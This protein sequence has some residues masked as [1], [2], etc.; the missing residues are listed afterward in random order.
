MKKP[1]IK[2]LNDITHICNVA[3]SFAP[4]R[5]RGV[6]MYGK[7]SFNLYVSVKRVASAFVL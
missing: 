3:E 5:L 6:K 4:F 2:H 7:P 1:Q